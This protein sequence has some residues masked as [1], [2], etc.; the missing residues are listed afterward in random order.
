MLHQMG[1][2]RTLKGHTDT[3]QHVLYSP[4]GNQIASA[5]LDK[6]VRLWDVETGVCGRVLTG[7]DQHVN[8]VA[9]LPQGDFIASVGSD[10]TVR[11]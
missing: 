6:S 7:H 4:E 10:E 11:L 8:G 9:Y 3:V 2:T 1:A 5:S